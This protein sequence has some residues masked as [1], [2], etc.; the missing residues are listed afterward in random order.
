M[1][2]ILLALMLFSIP[3]SAQ[4]KMRI[5][6]MDFEAKDIPKADSIKISEL[7]RNEIV[8]SGKFIVIERSQMG[9]ILKEQGLQQTGCVDIS[10]AVELGKVLSANKMLVGSVMKM[11]DKVIITGRIVDV[12]KGVAEFSEKEVAVD[13]NAESLIGAV[14]N[15]TGKLILRIT[16]ERPAAASEFSSVFLKDGSILEGKIISDKA[17]VLKINLLSG[18]QMDIQRKDV[19]R[20]LNNEEHKQKQY[21]YK[22]DGKIIEAFIVDEDSNSYT[23]RREYDSADEVKIAKN[24]INTV[25]KKKIEK[26]M[27]RSV[28]MMSRSSRWRIGLGMSPVNSDL[29]DYYEKFS[30]LPSSVQSAAIDVF[31]YRWRYNESDG[32]DLMFRLKVKL[33]SLKEISKLDYLKITGERPSVYTHLDKH[34]ELFT[35]GSDLGA[36][37]IMGFYY[38]GILWQPYAYIACQSYIVNE[39][40]SLAG[41]SESGETSYSLYGFSGGTGLEIGVTSYISLFGELNYG[42]NPVD[43]IIGEHKNVDGFNFLYGVSFRTGFAD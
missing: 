39:D 25:S 34:N 14:N 29:N 13:Q 12:E 32:I 5:A 9:L 10:C 6:I 41:N 42:Y 43:L 30:F 4:N 18:K 16:G 23:Y 8:N 28:E 33:Y 22:T 31:P 35:V 36:R 37:Y 24:E 2:K 26:V 20:I 27:T 15:F 21:I 40:I 1:K 19:L 7:V 11:G 3:L 17:N 38:F